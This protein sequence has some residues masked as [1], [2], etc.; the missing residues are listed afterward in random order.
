MCFQKYFF[1]ISGRG[2]FSQRVSNR[3]RLV[4]K[5]GWRMSTCFLKGSDPKILENLNTVTIFLQIKQLLN[6]FLKMLSRVVFLPV[7]LL[8]FICVLVVATV[9]KYACD[10][11]CRG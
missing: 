7:F 6:V 1:M 9:K 10:S 8:P 5:V 3:M 11:G 4:G 2:D